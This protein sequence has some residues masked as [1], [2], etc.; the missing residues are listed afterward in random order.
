MNIVL[1]STVVIVLALGGSGLACADVLFD[2][3]GQ[4]S[5]DVPSA[6]IGY[7]RG[8]SLPPIDTGLQFTMGAG[9]AP[10]QEYRIDSYGLAALELG[11]AN[12]NKMVLRLFTDAGNQ[13]GVEID[14]TEV[15]ILTSNAASYFP[16][17]ELQPLVTAGQRYWMIATAWEAPSGI[18]WRQSTNNDHVHASY[19]R[20]AA[21]VTIS[22][23]V[24][25]SVPSLQILGTV[26]PEPAGW[27][28]LVWG[29]S[30][31]GA[32]RRK[33]GGRGSR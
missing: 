2:N 4:A 24:Q 10:G 6:V 32:Y 11:S 12:T 31:I 22:F 26:V 25:D 33:G 16:L 19:S 28:L 8:P 3:L 5:G 9:L 23:N 15:E 29:A 7:F 27:C 20:E 17:S 30:A 13:P 14:T 18:S 21:A 1:R